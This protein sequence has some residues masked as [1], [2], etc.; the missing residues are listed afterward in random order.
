MTRLGILLTAVL[1]QTVTPPGSRG[2]IEGVVV[3]V[4]SEKPA[5]KASVEL[6]YVDGPRVVSRT[7]DVNSNGRFSFTNLPAGEGYELVA[8]GAGLLPTAYGQKRSRGPWTP[9][10]LAAGERLTNIRIEVAS[11]TQISGKVVDSSGSPQIGASV[12]TMRVA[13]INGH[14]VLQRASS[15]VTN[16]RGE[17]QFSNVTPGRYYVRVAPR[18]DG[19]ADA[20]FTNPALYDR[21]PVKRNAIT[22]D[23]EG[24]RTVYYPGEPI[25]TAKAVRVG[26]SDVLEDVDITVTKTRTSRVRGTVTNA[27]TGSRLQSALVMLQPVG[28]NPDSNWSRFVDMKEGTFDLRTVQ[29][30]KYFVY[31]SALVAD[32]ALTSRTLTEVK[33]GET[34]TL[35]IRVSPGREIKG[36]LALNGTGGPASFSGITITL[37]PDAAGPVDGTLSRDMNTL[38]SASTIATADGTFVITG[39]TPWDYHIQLSGAADTYVKSSRK[40]RVENSNNPPLE[41]VL[42]TDGARLDGHLV[43]SNQ[44]DVDVGQVILVPEDRSR[45]DLY[46]V[47]ST[48][49]TGRFQATAIPPGRYKLFA[50]RIVPEGAVLDPDFLAPFENQGK[51][52]VMES[53]GSDF[54]DLRLPEGS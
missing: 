16:T 29:P 14:R 35:D 40:V 20:L 24:Y 43:D 42:A 21:S 41:I 3:L 53:E 17:Y 47:M 9:I 33:S 10:N 22:K 19:S 49:R 51:A 38:P 45:R 15:T 11:I 23:Y 7:V 4:P 37:V 1:L 32:R 5:E 48:S 31:A 26:E 36:R 44:R 46:L 25:E 6:T 54:V 27:A 13:Y 28:S 34:N 2:S 18:N 12:L 8:T 30:G 50:W 39:V 52:V